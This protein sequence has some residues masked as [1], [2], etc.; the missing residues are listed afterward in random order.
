HD[1]RALAACVV[2]AATQQPVPKP[3]LERLPHLQQYL[4]RYDRALNVRAV[5]LAW[6]A[7]ARLTGDSLG[8]ARIR[9]RVIDRL[10]S[11]GMSPERDL[12]NFLRTAGHHDAERLR[13]VREQALELHKKALKWCDECEN[14]RHT[15]GHYVDLIFAFGLA[16]LGEPA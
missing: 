13:R 11:E 4:T 15:S 14:V 12:P 6:H 5:W 7:M 2:F 1:L 9:D 16:R 8:L 3:L 10:I